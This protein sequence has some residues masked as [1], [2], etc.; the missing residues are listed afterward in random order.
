MQISSKI[1]NIQYELL[2]LYSNNLSDED[3]LSIK[4]ILAEYFAMK[5]DSSFQIFC[6][7]NQL[8][9]DELLS[10]SKEHNRVSF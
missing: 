4:K 8:G 2:K 10:W 7:T 6:E 9:P 1:S 3:V 5:L